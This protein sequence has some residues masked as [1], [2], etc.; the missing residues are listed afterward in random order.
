M[1]LCTLDSRVIVK[2]RC[3]TIDERDH[4][5]IVD[6]CNTL[7]EVEL[8]NLVTLISMKKSTNITAEAASICGRCTK[9][10][11]QQQGCWPPTTPGRLAQSASAVLLADYQSLVV[12]ALQSLPSRA[13]GTNGTRNS[14]AEGAQAHSGATGAR[15]ASSVATTGDILFLA[16][17]LQS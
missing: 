16:G 5:I 14:N 3:S 9:R 7:N 1:I 12:E 11:H 10:R 13:R 8:C 4:F 2:F 6:P 15:A 17:Q